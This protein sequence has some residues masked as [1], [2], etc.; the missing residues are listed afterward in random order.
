MPKIPTLIEMLES[1]VHFGH[2]TGRWHPKMKPFIFGARGGIHIIDLEKTVEALQKTL[3]YMKGVVT[4]GGTVLFVGTKRQARAIVEEAAKDC[5]MPYVT[6][7]WLGGTLTN[8][9]EIKR[10]L[11]RLRDL[12]TQRDTGALKKY[13]KLEQLMFTREI[14]ELEKKVGGIQNLERRPEIIFVIDTRHEKTAVNEAKVTG[15]T[16]AAI[17]DTNV[18]PNGILY[19]IP[20]NDDAVKSIALITKLVAEAVKEGKQE[21]AKIALQKAAETAKE[22]VKTPAV[23]VAAEEKK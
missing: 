23:P 3:D 2:Q 15:T 16:I 18:K 6:E 10:V 17:C 7:R 21:A 11:R 9:V 4:R 19:C 22:Q 14:D 13:T 5:G 12:K 20:A 8:F 1:G